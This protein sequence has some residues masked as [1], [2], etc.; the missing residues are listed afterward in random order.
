MKLGEQ[1]LIRASWAFKPDKNTTLPKP[2]QRAALD[3]NPQALG[4]LKFFFRA[5]TQIQSQSPKPQTTRRF[6]FVL[7]QNHFTMA[8][9]IIAIAVYATFIIRFILFM[10]A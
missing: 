1:R 7:S 10:S 5:A 9:A 6:S 2:P 4:G 3:P 8:A